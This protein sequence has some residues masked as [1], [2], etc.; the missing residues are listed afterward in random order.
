MAAVVCG[1]RRPHATAVSLALLLAVLAALCQGGS[2]RGGQ[3]VS[4]HLMQVRLGEAELPQDAAEDGEGLLDD[5]N[6]ARERTLDEDHAHV[7]RIQRVGRRIDANNDMKLS[8]DE[9]HQFAQAIRTK[10]WWDQTSIIQ[11]RAD[12]DGDGLVS[13]EELRAKNL[14]SSSNPRH[15]LVRFGAADA[16]GD[17]ALSKEEM[18]A[19]LHPELGGKVLQVEVAHLLDR[20]DAGGDAALDFQEFARM[21]QAQR[22]DFDHEGGL[23]DFGL[24]DADG[25]GLLSSEEVGHLLQGHRQ[26]SDSIGKVVGLVDGDGDGHIHVDHEVPHHLGN[27]LDSEFVEDFFFHRHAVHHEL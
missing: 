10:E 12:Q 11:A 25:N 15:Q 2:L 14:Y 9:L 27:L 3:G 16:D 26:L 17:G 6:Q 19:F 7:A 23:E 5:G 20:W 21:C 24:H 22:D 13:L 1:S 18:H 8:F 4:G